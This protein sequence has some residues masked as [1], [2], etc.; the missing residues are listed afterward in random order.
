MK[1]SITFLA[2]AVTAGALSMGAFAA[3][4]P[5]SRLGSSA[6]F[7]AEAFLSSD[8]KAAELTESRSVKNTLVIAENEALVVPKGC[9]L[10]L[11]KGC[12]VEGTLYIENGGYLAVSGGT[13]E[14][15]GS[16]VNDGT[17]S[18]GAKAGL[19]VFSGG[20]LFTSAQGVFKSKTKKAFADETSTVVCLGESAVSGCSDDSKRALCPNALSAV[21]VSYNLDGVDSSKQLSAEDALKA[22]DTEYFLLDSAPAGGV[23]ELVTILFDNGSAIKIQLVDEKIVCIGGAEMRVL[24]KT[25]E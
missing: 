20:E 24:L 22:A 15:T 12:R 11:K 8:M 25:V 1:K 14:I 4:V 23:V 17:V 13:L 3:D 10:T 6:E 16:V 21:E 7:F 19:N 2:A 9:K 5:L 18:V